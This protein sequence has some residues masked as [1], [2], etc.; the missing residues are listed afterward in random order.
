MIQILD[1]ASLQG[2]VSLGSLG[3]HGFADVLKRNPVTIYRGV[4]PAESRG[5]TSNRRQQQ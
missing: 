4:M 1:K 2:D 3:G 5:E